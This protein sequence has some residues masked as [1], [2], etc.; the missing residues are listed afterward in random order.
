AHSATHGGKATARFA[1]AGGFDGGVEC[2]QV[3]LKGITIDDAK[4]VGDLA[5]ARIDLAHSSDSLADDLAT[6]FALGAGAS[7]E[8]VGLL[9]V[10]GVLCDGTGHLLNAGSSLSE[11]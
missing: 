1:R 8:L 9:G 6:L 4:D 11:G 7:G 2:Q 3:G 5:A 10:P